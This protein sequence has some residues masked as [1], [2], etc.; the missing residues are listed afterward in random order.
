MSDIRCSHASCC[1][2]SPLQNRALH[3]PL[4]KGGSSTCLI[5]T[6]VKILICEVIYGHV[7]LDIGK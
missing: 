6:H 4:L 7:F 1:T 5:V 2:I 3:Y